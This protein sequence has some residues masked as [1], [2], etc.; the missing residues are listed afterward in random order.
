MPGYRTMST[1]CVFGMRGVRVAMADSEQDAVD[2]TIR[3]SASAKRLRHCARAL[4]NETEPPESE[5]LLDQ[6][7]P[8]RLEICHQLA[9]AQVENIQGGVRIHVV[10]DSANDTAIIRDELAARIERAAAE[11]RC[12]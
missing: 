12:D 8:R 10:P 6:T 4:L 11:N 9:T 5:A 7:A 1:S 2:I 3:M